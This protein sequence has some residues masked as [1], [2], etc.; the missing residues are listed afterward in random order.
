MSNYSGFDSLQL[1]IGTYVQLFGFC[2]VVKQIG[3]LV[4]TS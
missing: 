3:Y 2:L 4:K 1:P